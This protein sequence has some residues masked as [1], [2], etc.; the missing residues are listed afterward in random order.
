MNSQIIKYLIC[1]LKCPEKITFKDVFVESLRRY[2]LK[3]QKKYNFFIHKKYFL[4]NRKSSK[5]SILVLMG[6]YDFLWEVTLRRIYEYGEKYNVILVN[7]GGLN[8][9]KSKLL[10]KNYDWSYFESYPA[11]LESAENYVIS[12]I[13]ESP[14]IIKIDDDIFIT[15]DTFRKLEDGYIKL[16]KKDF[17]ISFV[18]PLINVNTIGYYYFLKTTNLINEF[19]KIFE[20]PNIFRNW[21]RQKIWY[22]GNAAKWIW[23]HSLPLNELGNEIAIMNN[24]LF[25]PI[26]TRFSIGLIL[27]EKS[28]FNKTNGFISNLPRGMNKLFK[29]IDNNTS[30]I[31]VNIPLLPDIDESS[32]NF[33]S[34]WA[35]Y[36]KFMILDSFAGHFSYYPQTNIM[37]KW[38]E[39]NKSSLIKDLN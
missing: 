26:P 30:G 38:Y 1:T 7:P 22:D 29:N 34:D 4:D 10:A 11:S 3:T 19:S 35:H 8:G 37:K 9:T 33:Y 5:T 28:F 23:E 6:K 18:A 14:F 20:Y 21:K 2:Y 27:F 16:K 12:N 39:N 31:Y 25:E 15:P 24:G 13:I 36:G 32:I 17:D